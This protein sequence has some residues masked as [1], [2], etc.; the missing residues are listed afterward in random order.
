MVGAIYTCIPPDYPQIV[1]LSPI[2]ERGYVEHLWCD[3]IALGVKTWS[4]TQGGHQGPKQRDWG[5]QSSE[6]PTSNQV[7]L[8]NRLNRVLLNIP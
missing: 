7:P 1:G 8:F 3:E 5:D 4:F 2:D 6:P